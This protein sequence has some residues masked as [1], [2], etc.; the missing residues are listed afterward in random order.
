MKL[1][2]EMNLKGITRDLLILVAS[3]LVAVGSYIGW[4]RLTY[5]DTKNPVQALKQAKTDQ[6][7]TLLVFHKTGC[8]DCKAAV[9]DINRGINRY[10][11]TYNHVVVDTNKSNLYEQY[12]VTEVPTVIHLHQGI[13]VDRY[14]G[15]DQSQITQILSGR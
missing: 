9:V 2:R 15:T 5:H 1:E 8:P 6:Q 14:S 4:Q 7:D 3:L 11:D 13:E 12:G 10:K